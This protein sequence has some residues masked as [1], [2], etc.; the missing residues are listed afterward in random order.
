MKI[1]RIESGLALH[2]ELDIATAEQFDATL[3]EAIV[4]SSGDFVLDLRDLEFMDSG[5]VKAL[6]RI[7]AL[8]GREER[9]LAVICP[10]GPVR[11]ILEVVGVADL[12]TIFS[13]AD[14]A[15]AAL[16]RVV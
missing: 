4:E 16:T 15:K 10:P 3:Q 5:G 12:F 13:S 1:E 2:G 11:R 6:V 14:D 9:S 7:R 8:L